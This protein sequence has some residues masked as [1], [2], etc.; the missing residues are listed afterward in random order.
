MRESILLASLLLSVISPDLAR[1]QRVPV[2]VENGLT[3]VRADETIELPWP[4]VLDHLKTASPAR[5]RVIDVAGNEVPSQIIDE[6]ANGIP[7]LLIFQAS[8]RRKEKKQF[9]IEDSV[10]AVKPVSRVHVIH[11]EPRDDVAWESDRIAFRIYGEGLKKTPDA[12]S[13]S[14]IDVW[15][16]KVRTPV[17]EKW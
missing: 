2:T 10:P 8:F 5:I 4:A 12:V 14:G 15:V 1:A 11:D 17:L 9:Y 7:D 3:I 13:T 16:K 6:D